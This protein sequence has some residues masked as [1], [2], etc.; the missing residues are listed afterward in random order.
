M[1]AV[2]ETIV[3][4]NSESRDWVF[5]IKGMIRDRVIDDSSSEVCLGTVFIS[6]IQRV[7]GSW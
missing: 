4:V 2:K 3:S 5:F 7:Y 1:L 6:L